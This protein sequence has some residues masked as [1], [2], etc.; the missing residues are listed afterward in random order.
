MTFVFLGAFALIA[1]W[2]VSSYNR[3]VRL[4]SESNSAWAD[5]DVQ[6]ERRWD[7]IPNLVETAKVAASRER[8]ILEG[9]IAA[10]GRAMSAVTVDEKADA[11]RALTVALSGVFG[12]AESY[13]QLRSME[14]FLELQ[15][16]LERVEEAVQNARRYY[17]AVVRDYN[18]RVEAFPGN[19]LARPMGFEHRRFFSLRDD[20]RRVGPRLSLASD[21]ASDQGDGAR[22][23]LG[24]GQRSP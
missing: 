10:R 22:S 19:L 1:L 21:G 16:S 2:L 6:L 4:R 8:D 7:L 20:S 3:L 9:V 15:R 13:P 24:A 23:A 18:T 5:I 17:N 11:E 14:S 12:L